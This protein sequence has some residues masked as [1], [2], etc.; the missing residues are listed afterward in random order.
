MIKLVHFMKIVSEEQSMIRVSDMKI[1]PTADR[2]E[3]QV[4]L[5]FVASYLKPETDSKSS[6]GSKKKGKKK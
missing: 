5:T 4:D 3:L 6:K 2:R 1:F